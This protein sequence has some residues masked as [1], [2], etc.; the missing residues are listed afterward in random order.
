MSTNKITMQLTV[1]EEYGFVLLGLFATLI[2]NFYLIIN[3]AKL[4]KKFGIQ[5]PALYAT[6]KHLSNDCKP[7]DIIKFN[8]AQRAHQNTCEAQS[9]IQLLGV[10]NGFFYPMTAAVCL[11][12]FAVGRV[13]YG[14]GYVNKGFKGRI[15]G[16]LITHLGDFPLMIL[17][18]VNGL[19]LA[20]LV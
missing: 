14:H 3:V 13:V 10:V 6:D 5:Y 1:P 17:T 12:L 15:P 4:R 18:L 2:A 8:C 11:G 20:G 16:A 7:D 19:S 9:T